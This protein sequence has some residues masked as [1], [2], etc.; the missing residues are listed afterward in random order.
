[1]IIFENSGEIDPRL[2]SLIGVNVKES[3]SAIGYFGTGL[4]YA[5]ACLSRW[6]E[7]ITIQ[8]GLNEFSFRVEKTQIRGQDFG[9]LVMQS[10]LDQLHLGFTTALGKNWEP[11]MVYRE[12]WCN[13]HDEPNARVYETPNAPRPTAGI[14]RVIA[15]GAKIQSAHE[16]RGEF[17]LEGR[18]PLHALKGLEIYEGEGKS[19][20][21]RGIAVQKPDKPSIYTYNILDQIY[22][23]EDRTAG[24]WTTDPII[25]RGLAQLK[26]IAVIDATL[27]APSTALESRLDYDYVYHP[28]EAWDARARHH[29]AT[30]MTAIPRSVASKYAAKAEVNVCP[31]CKRPMEKSDD[32][33]PF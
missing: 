29:V 10:P 13:A 18:T 22:L 9:V 28:G 21:Y 19:I 11:W 4:K 30:H 32:E 6:E 1:M 3:P 23:T 12:L 26:D 20:F 24:S 2:I 14:T 25:A 15:S 7:H 33:I 5:V 27:T 16:S 8:S 17:I 31:T